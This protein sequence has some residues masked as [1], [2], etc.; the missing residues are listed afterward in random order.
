MGVSGAIVTWIPL[1]EMVAPWEA[2][3]LS[4]RMQGEPFGRADKALMLALL[5][6]E[7][8]SHALQY[9]GPS[10]IYVSHSDL[11]S[12]LDNKRVEWGSVNDPATRVLRKVYRL[13]AGRIR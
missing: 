13:A 2:T 9:E 3:P 7:A 5:A 1:A 12:H 10:T 11:T 4:N 8:T 6:L